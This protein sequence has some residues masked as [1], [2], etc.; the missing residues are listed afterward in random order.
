MPQLKVMLTSAQ[1]LT[2]YQYSQCKSICLREWGWMY[3]ELKFFR[4][5]EIKNHIV[6][7][8]EN[9]DSSPGGKLIGWAMLGPYDPQKL[10]EVRPDDTVMQVY[11][12][13]EYRNQGIGTKLIKRLRKCADKEFYAVPH[14][15]LSGAFWSKF[16][17]YKV[18]SLRKHWISNARR[19]RKALL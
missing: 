14:D 15:R 11:V 4:K 10:E 8:W 16:Q 13:A 1:E 6:C 7:I 5:S 9:N 3:S 18:D 2:P 19:R 12:R 17:R